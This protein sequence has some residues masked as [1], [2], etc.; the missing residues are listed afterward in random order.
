VDRRRAIIRAVLD[1]AIVL[2][3]GPTPKGQF[4]KAF[5]W[6]RVELRWRA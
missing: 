5:D 2:P 3:A 4:G 6:D 1:A